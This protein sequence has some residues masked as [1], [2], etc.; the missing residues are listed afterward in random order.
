MSFRNRPIPGA[1]WWRLAGA[2][3]WLVLGLVIALPMS[4]AQSALASASQLGALPTDV[5]PEFIEAALASGINP[6]SLTS[7]L[8]LPAGVNPA[9]SAFQLPGQLYL[10]APFVYGAL[11]VRPKLSYS[12][13]YN[14]GLP[15]TPGERSETWI[16]TLVGGLIAT[17][18]ERFVL[19][20]TLSQAWYSGEDFTDTLD[21]DL[22]FSGAFNVGDTPV[23]LVQTYR[24]DSSPQLESFTQTDE[25]LVVTSLSARKPLNRIWSLEASGSQTL[26]FIDADEDQYSWTGSMRTRATLTDRT[27]V[28]LGVSGGYVAMAKNA[29]TIYWAPN[30]QL[31]W[32]PG[33]K[34]TL[35]AS[36][37]YQERY[38]YDDR[39]PKTVDATY[40]F[41]FAWQPWAYTTIT[42][43]SRQDLQPSLFNGQTKFSSGWNTGLQQRLLGRLFLNIDYAID[44]VEYRPGPNTVDPTPRSDVVE[45][46]SAGLSFQVIERLSINLTLQ[47]TISESS[48]ADFDYDSTAIGA[49]FSYIF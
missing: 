20:Y 19:D 26:R 38:T 21:H 23:N 13:L 24:T 39:T 25:E 32:Q 17:W 41:G 40:D 48:L 1:G 29:D 35:S 49:T 4:R 36:L 14:D 12:T 34:L 6:S 47:R 3:G 15:S 18:G 16:D 28:A 5:P 44:E 2:P 22:N 43:R 37:G 45:I 10:D 42:A 8:N 30:S 9:G 11:S 33:D 46:V 7:G 27:T 31:T